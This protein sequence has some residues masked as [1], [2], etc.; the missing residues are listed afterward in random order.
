[1]DEGALCT[2]PFL[3]IF[4]GFPSFF[5]CFR[6]CLLF[7]TVFSV[8]PHHPIFY[9]LPSFFTEQRRHAQAMGD[10]GWKEDVTVTWLAELQR[11]QEN[12][13]KTTID[14]IADKVILIKPQYITL[15]IR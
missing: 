4:K 14:T 13:D 6:G 8:R 11:M 12:E 10:D 7:N 2:Y 3:V 9:K 5:H 15:L 1:M